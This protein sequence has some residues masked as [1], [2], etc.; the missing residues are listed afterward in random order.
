MPSGLRGTALSGRH[1]GR[2]RVRVRRH[3]GQAAVVGR[4]REGQMRR[5]GRAPGREHAASTVGHLGGRGGGHVV[6]SAV[7]G[8]AVVRG[9]DEAGAVVRRR[10]RR[11]RRR[12]GRRVRR[13]QALHRPTVPGRGRAAAAR[14]R[15]QPHSP[16]FD[17][18]RCRRRRHRHGAPTRVGR[19]DWPPASAARLL[20]AVSAAHHRLSRTFPRP[21]GGRLLH[22]LVFF[23]RG[24]R[25]HHLLSLQRFPAAGS[26]GRRRNAAARVAVFAF[27]RGRRMPFDGRQQLRFRPAAG[28]VLFFQAFGRRGNAAAAAAV[29]TKGWFWRRI[30][31]TVVSRRH[32]FMLFHSNFVVVLR[33]LLAAARQ[34][35][36]G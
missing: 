4:Q 35:V 36:G 3:D 16:V 34:R 24:R 23:L 18:R 26:F 33:A 29:T 27:R 2:R 14:V 31:F 19:R 13:R 21:L 7:Q 5:H 30:I 32:A 28:V 17:R 22:V 15:R 11:R 1:G 10:R 20:A 8:P 6:Q 12:R 25:G 9:H